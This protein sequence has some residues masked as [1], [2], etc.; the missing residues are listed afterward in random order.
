[1]PSSDSHES[2]AVE[3]VR[4]TAL[5]RARVTGWN[6]P[7]LSA[8]TTAH[9]V[10]D[11]YVAFLAPVLPLVVMRFDLSLTLAGLLATILNTSAA[12]SQPV[13]GMFADQMRRRIFVVL[14]PALTVLAMGSMGLAPSYGTLIVL[15]LIAG[16][17]TA[18]FH[19]QGAS[20]AGLA[21]GN[22]KGVGLSLF[23]AGGEL[24]YALGPVV[25]ALA[26]ASFGLDVTWVVALPGLALC[27]LLWKRLAA[28]TIDHAERPQSL[29]ADL[30]GVWRPLALLWTIVVLRSIIISAFITFLPL[31]LRERGGSIVAGGAA[32]FLFG[33]VGAVGGL[34]GG[35]LADRVGRRAL[36]AVSLL[37]G[38]PLLLLFLHAQG[39]WSYLALAGGGIA[40]Y[41]SAAITIVMAQEVLPH[42]ASVASSIVMGLA[43]GAAGLSLTAVGAL[44]DAVG[45]ATAL[46]WVMGLAVVALLFVAFLP[47]PEPRTSDLVS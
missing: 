1:M 15:L 8:A 19:P 39:V 28:Q 23:V 46:T 25:I 20:T 6:F 24:G 30:R 14:G 12:M 7:L 10:N 21:S 13:F 17:G 38:T 41:L 18:T 37:L 4:V 40:L 31:L 3:G 27:V 47:N 9:F 5:P 34:I 42:R 22:R 2:V 36:L 29:A 35:A 44:A 32:I 33:G 11:F 16:T 45:L 43:W 26:V